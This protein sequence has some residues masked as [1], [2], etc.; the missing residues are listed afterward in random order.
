MRESTQGQRDIGSECMHGYVLW[1]IEKWVHGKKLKRTGQ[2]GGGMGACTWEEQLE[3]TEVLLQKQWLLGWDW[4][5]TE[6]I[7]QPL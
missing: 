1:G 2:E 5:G 6:L 7:F 4:E 3:V